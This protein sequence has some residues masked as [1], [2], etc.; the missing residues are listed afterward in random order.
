MEDVR[1]SRPERTRG[2]IP[3]QALAVLR[4]AIERGELEPGRQLSENELAERLGV[5]RT[6]VR[7]ALIRLSDD[8][9]VEIVP[10][11]G[12]F[13]SRISEGAVYDAQFVREA[14][15]CAAV[16]LAAATA[17]RADVDALDGLILRQREIRDGDE[18]DHFYVLDDEFHSAI[19]EMSGHGIAWSL[20]Q[21]ANGHLNRVRHLSLTQP[22]YLTEMV[23]EHELVVEAIRRNDP[24][25]AEAALRHHLKMVVAG[26]PTLRS[27]HPD[28]FE[29]GPSS[30]ALS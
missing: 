10:Q 7:E 17:D 6:P 2:P 24:D 8:R 26:L 22:R 14:L 9:L 13:V 11:H 28:Y 16:R 25:A 4:D 19:C 27:E 15:E 5:S 20:A 18:Y 30:P 12:T 21:R 1:I 23:A 29:A 3:E